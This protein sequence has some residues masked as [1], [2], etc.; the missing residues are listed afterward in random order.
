MSVNGLQEERNL[1]NMWLN[2]DGLNNVSA[3]YCATCVMLLPSTALVCHQ[4]KKERPQ[5]P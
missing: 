5:V 1:A 3:T 4:S 2:A